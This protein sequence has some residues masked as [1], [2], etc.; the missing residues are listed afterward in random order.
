MYVAQQSIYV[1]IATMEKEAISHEFTLS[2]ASL[3]ALISALD[4]MLRTWT[5]FAL[6]DHEEGCHYNSICLFR[7]IIHC[8]TTKTLVKRYREEKK[9]N[10][11]YLGKHIVSIKLNN[12]NTTKKNINKSILEFQSPI[13][14]ETLFHLNSRFIC[15]NFPC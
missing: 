12:N 14:L 6:L 4:F 9:T 10:C 5:C 11:N 3:V 8:N 7:Y 1:C 13:S 2:I 15:L